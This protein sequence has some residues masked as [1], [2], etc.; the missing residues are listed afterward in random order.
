[1]QA[2]KCVQIEN[3]KPK[4]ELSL[5][6]EVNHLRQLNHPYIMQVEDFYKEATQY[7]VVTE[8]LE[9]GELVDKLLDKVYYEEEEAKEVIRQVR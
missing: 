6:D 1:M 2:A 5:L 7:I 9:G 3:L 4:E 8:L